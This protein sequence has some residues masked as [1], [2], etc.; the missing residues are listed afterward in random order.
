MK[1]N[2][3]GGLKVPIH[4]EAKEGEIAE[5]VLIVGDPLRA[6]YIAEKKLKDYQLVNRVRNMFFY[7]GFYNEHRVTVASSGM[8]CPSMGIYSYE[9]FKF[10]QVK[11]MIRLGSSC[12][13]N[14]DVSLSDIVN[15]ESV[16]TNSVYPLVAGGLTKE[17]GQTIICRKSVHEIL[18]ATA[19]EIGV[20]IK[21][22]KVICSDVFTP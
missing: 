12:S 20:K 13:Y 19:R 10:Y 6:K 2:L 14:Q 7:T 22:G 9:L 1:I 8:G 17:E 3:K 18:T 5:I 16:Y 4:I 11:V 15:T 21:T